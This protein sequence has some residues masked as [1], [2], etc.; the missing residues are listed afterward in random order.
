MRVKL[1]EQYQVERE[2]ICLRLLAIMG[3]TDENNSFCLC[4]LDADVDKQNRIM[5]MKEEIRRVFSMSELSSYRNME[6][7]RPWL[8][9]LKSVLKKQNYK[10]DNSVTYRSI[11]QGMYK[12][13]TKYQIRKMA[14]I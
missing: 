2:D 1:S 10:V 7:K 11:E 3:I 4:D 6:C 14:I 13:T 9:I 8:S 5:E 12:T